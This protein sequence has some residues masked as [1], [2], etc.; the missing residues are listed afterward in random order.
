VHEPVVDE[1]DRERRRLEAGT[2]GGRGGRTARQLGGDHRPRGVGVASPEV[3]APQARPGAGLDE[4]TDA[5][6]GVVEHDGEVRHVAT[7]PR[8]V[9]GRGDRPR[10][11]DDRE[12][13]VVGGI[14]VVRTAAVD[15][16]GRGHV[17]P[18]GGEIG[19]ETLAEHP[20][21]VDHHDPRRPNLLRAGPSARRFGTRARP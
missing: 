6:A 8:Q 5:R 13:G 20:V 17:V 9:P 7:E 16:R 1:G 19:D 2:R 12:R 11:G 10:R 15:G 3:E 4:R 21:G 14:L 18:Q